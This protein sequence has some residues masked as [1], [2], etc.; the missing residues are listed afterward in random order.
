MKKIFLLLLIFQAIWFTAASQ[1]VGIGTNSPSASAIL[2]IKSS[3][4]GLLFPRTSTTSRNAMIGVKGLMVY[5]TT[6]SQLYYHTGSAWQMVTSGP[7]P[8]TYWNPFGNHIISSNTG[9][10]GIGITPA[11]K[12][13]I[14][15]D[16]MITSDEPTLRLYGSTLAD[17][18][19]IRF[20]IYNGNPNFNITQGLN[21]LWISRN[22]GTYG[23]TN[24]L[25]IS[26]DGYVG[27]GHSNPE[28]RLHID[29][30]TDVG[31]AS[32]G[33]LE[34]GLTSSNN[35][36]I[37]N[38]EIQARNNVVV[39]R[40]VLNN[41]GGPVQIGSAVTPAGYSLSVNGKAIC[42]ELKIQA[43]SNW[44]DYVFKDDYTLKSFDELRQ[45]IS[46]KQHLPGIPD[47]NTIAQNGIE[48]GD[49]QKRMME[50]IEELTLYILALES[51]Q[52]AL[53]QEISSLKSLSSH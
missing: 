31:N 33:Y 12:L 22:L 27:I 8:N 19:Q 15:G 48:I 23:F 35:I 5:D 26:E 7:H 43:S 49:M 11:Y 10:V 45:Y 4:K 28:T 34:L 50:K 18:A 20:Q 41:G 38:N 32:G 30:G 24:D 13:S 1:A 44:P 29:G 46:I 17:F 6:L 21:N 16:V 25:V 9:N 2:D 39:S 36:G 3:T 51:K 47:A 37:D 52:Q 40:L 14:D 53:E 42:E